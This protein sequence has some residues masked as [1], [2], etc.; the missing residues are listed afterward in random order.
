MDKRQTAAL[1]HFAA[2]CGDYRPVP[3]GCGWQTLRYLLAAGYI[4]QGSVS[5]GGKLICRATEEGRRAL[6]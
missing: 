3:R 5:V 6:D 1:R 4:R 2:Y